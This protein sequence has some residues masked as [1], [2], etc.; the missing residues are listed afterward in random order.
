M[1]WLLKHKLTK[2]PYKFHQKL[3]GSKRGAPPIFKERIPNET[4]FFTWTRAGCPLLARRSIRSIAPALKNLWYILSSKRKLPGGQRKANGAPPA[5]E[6]AF[7]FGRSLSRWRSRPW[8]F[9]TRLS[10]AQGFGTCRDTIQTQHQPP[11]SAPDPPFSS[12][13][14]AFEKQDADKRQM[15]QILTEL[16]G[17][18][19]TAVAKSCPLPTLVVCGSRDWANRTSSKKLAKLL[20]RGRY[21]EIAD[22]GHLLN[23]EKPYELAQAIKEFVAGF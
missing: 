16:K 22:G 13:S 14:Q 18:N 11:L 4:D 17:L 15:L 19:L 21:Q 8:S 5:G 12:P 2:P 7:Y 23:T 10:A 6:R 20:P 9:K 1:D 3:S